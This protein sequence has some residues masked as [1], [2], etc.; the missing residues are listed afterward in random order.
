MAPAPSRA[1]TVLASREALHMSMGLSPRKAGLIA[2]GHPPPPALEPS[3][4]PRPAAEAQ[5]AAPAHTLREVDWPSLPSAAHAPRACGRDGQQSAHLSARARPG[6]TRLDPPT[7]VL[8]P[9]ALVEGSIPSPFWNGGPAVCGAPGSPRSPRDLA[10]LS[11]AS[12]PGTAAL[13]LYIDSKLH[14]T[15]ASPLTR[16]ALCLP[17]PLPR[18]LLVLRRRAKRSGL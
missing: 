4:P 16:R 1:M 2:T 8:H 13:R 5:P 11:L 12:N 18:R 17:L 15:L 14:S 10:P 6:A 3:A 9:D 7:R